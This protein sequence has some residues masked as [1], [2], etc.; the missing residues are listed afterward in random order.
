LYNRRER[1]YPY[2][3]TLICYAFCGFLLY[4]L[5]LPAFFIGFMAG[6]IVSLIID[7]IVTSFWK[8]SAH[9]TGIGGLLA[10]VT[11]IYK[12]FDGLNLPFLLS[13]ILLV[14]LLGTS[15]M[16]LKCHNLGQ[17]IAGTL[18]GLLSIY[19]LIYFSFELFS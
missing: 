9:M 6:C 1:F 13:T 19:I 8:I 17:V 16:Y 5:K 12:Y 7:L 14:G 15:R 3:I 18:N 4:K 2:I 10:V 11:I